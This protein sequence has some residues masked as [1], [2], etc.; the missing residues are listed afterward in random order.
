MSPVDISLSIYWV[1]SVKLSEMALPYSPGQ[2][3]LC[4]ASVIAFHFP[5]ISVK[6]TAIMICMASDS[7]Y[8]DLL[9]AKPVLN[10][11]VKWSRQPSF[12]GTQF[13]GSFGGWALRVGFCGVKGKIRL[14]LTSEGVDKISG[15]SWAGSG[16]KYPKEWESTL[17]QKMTF[18]TLQIALFPLSHYFAQLR[19]NELTL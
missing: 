14:W 7:I 6:T 19:I 9:H 1:S 15:D 2:A 12:P 18:L 5:L 17:T 4:K 13:S 8:W 11:V 3:C 10:V 16:D